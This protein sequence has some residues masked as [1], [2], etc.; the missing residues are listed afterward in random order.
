MSLDELKE[1]SSR[2]T[3]NLE[4]MLAH[5]S[6]GSVGTDS[7]VGMVSLDELDEW[8][9]RHMQLHDELEKMKKSYGQRVV[10]GWSK[11]KGS[12]RSFVYRYTPF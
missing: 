11:D 9:S 1:L 6:A 12:D 8:S 10:L 2:F 7:V 5:R 4:M 3:K